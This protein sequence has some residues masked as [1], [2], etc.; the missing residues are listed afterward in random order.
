MSLLLWW[1]AAA[2]LE[3][4]GD[5]TG[6]C[7]D[8]IFGAEGDGGNCLLTWGTRNRRCRDLG[9]PLQSPP[10]HRCHAGDT[11]TPRPPGPSLPLQRPGPGAAAQSPPPPAGRLLGAR[12]ASP[13]PRPVG[14]P[15]WFL[16]PGS[17]VGERV[18]AYR[19]RSL[20]WRPGPHLPGLWPGWAREGPALGCGVGG[21]ATSRV[22]PPH[23]AK[24][25]PRATLSRELGSLLLL[26]ALSGQPGP[27]LIP[28]GPGGQVRSAGLGGARRAVWAQLRPPSCPPARAAPSYRF[29]SSPFKE[30][31]SDLS[32]LIFCDSRIQLVDVVA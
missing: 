11:V 13:G 16:A 1:L 19:E 8:G 18:G 9:P 4:D 14:G 17:G 23:F 29:K 24:K 21:L 30:L 25:P 32:S 26:P 20:G 6:I 5:L 2:G 7:Q 22:T 3:G 31:I 10:P 15:P 27:K 12:P 28:W